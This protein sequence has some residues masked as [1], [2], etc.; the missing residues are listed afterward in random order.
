M[1]KRIEE[2]IKNYEHGFLT[3]FEFLY[4]L[5]ELLG[6]SEFEGCNILNKFTTDLFQASVEINVGKIKHALLN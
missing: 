5:H 4:Q 2:I 1:K 3:K 6:R